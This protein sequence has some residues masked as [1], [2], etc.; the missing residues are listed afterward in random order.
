MGEQREERKNKLERWVY[1]RERNNRGY[2]R[3]K[4]DQFKGE[5]G[6]K[7]YAGEYKKGSGNTMRQVTIKRG[8]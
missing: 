4:I 1:V 6:G 7:R 3:R 2:K 8:V 5:T